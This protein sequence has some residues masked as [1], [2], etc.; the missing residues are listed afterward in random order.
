ME[1]DE[2]LLRIGRSDVTDESIAEVFLLY[3]IEDEVVS[4][5]RVIYDTLL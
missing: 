5:F 3:Q 4:Y 2:P 1:F